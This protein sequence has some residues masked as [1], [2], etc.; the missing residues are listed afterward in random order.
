MPYTAETVNRKP[1]TGNFFIPL[2]PSKKGYAEP[3]GAN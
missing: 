3:S 2:C 1:V